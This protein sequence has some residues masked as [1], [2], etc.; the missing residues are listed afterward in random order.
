MACVSPVAEGITEEIYTGLFNHDAAADMDAL[1]A[2][3]RRSTPT[4]NVRPIRPATA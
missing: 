4:D 2:L 1:G 3:D